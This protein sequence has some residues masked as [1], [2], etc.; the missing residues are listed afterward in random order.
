[1]DYLIVRDCSGLKNEHEDQLGRR[2]SPQ[3]SVWIDFVI[4]LR[5][6][7]IY[8]EQFAIKIGAS[9]TLCE[10]LQSTYHLLGCTGN[11]ESRVSRANGNWK[12]RIGHGNGKTREVCIIRNPLERRRQGRVLP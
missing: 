8:V 11:H 2:I 6:T 7:V 10:P 4:A 1:M 3:P 5:C 12:C 9:E